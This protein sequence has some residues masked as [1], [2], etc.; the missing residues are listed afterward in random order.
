MNQ[1]GRR[2]RRDRWFK[3]PGNI[4]FI[5]FYSWQLIEHGIAAQQSCVCSPVEK[6]KSR[7]SAGQRLNKE[8]R[9]WVGGKGCLALSY[10]DPKL[11]L[12]D[13]LVHAV[14]ECHESTLP[15]WARAINLWR[16][17]S[18]MQL[19]IRKSMWNFQTPL[20]KSHIWKSGGKPKPF[21][22]DFSVEV[23]FEENQNH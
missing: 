4:Y 6:A 19:S 21:Q 20:P 23:P 17:F 9:Y 7:V 11:Y 5:F 2:R 12:A 18:G 22:T 1:W 14:C 10:D 15:S 3:W 16:F 8:F 13:D